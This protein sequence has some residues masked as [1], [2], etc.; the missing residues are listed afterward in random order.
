M[1]IPVLPTLNMKPEVGQDKRRLQ[2]AFIERGLASY[3]A[4]KQSGIY[5]TSEEVLRKLDEML[6]NAIKKSHK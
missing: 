4:A 5:F 2:Q 3:E 6:V 1:N